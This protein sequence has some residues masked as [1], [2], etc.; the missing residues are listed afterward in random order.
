VPALSKLCL[1]SF[2]ARH[3]LSP[4]EEDVVRLLLEGLNTPA[5]ADRLNISLHTVRDHLKRL[6]RK[7]GVRSRSELLSLVSSAGVQASFDGSSNRDVL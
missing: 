7:T 4:R 3:N 2:C 5:M 6:Y 1:E